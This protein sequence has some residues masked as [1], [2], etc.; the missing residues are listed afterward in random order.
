MPPAYTFVG[1]G[2][3]FY[4]ETLEF[5]K[6]LKETGVENYGKNKNL[7]QGGQLSSGIPISY[8]DVILNVK[9]YA[10]NEPVTIKYTN[11][12][13]MRSKEIKLEPGEKIDSQFEI[14][15]LIKTKFDIAFTIKTEDTGFNI[16]IEI[17]GRSYG[18]EEIGRFIN[19]YIL[20]K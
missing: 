18:Y 13:A 15:D 19:E 4:Q 8:H 14:E 5:V 11:C 16:D 1:D 2:E 10:G 3:P 9:G 12:G 20:V 6:H 17:T 7:N